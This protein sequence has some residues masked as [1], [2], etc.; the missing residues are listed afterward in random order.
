MNIPSSPSGSILLSFDVLGL[1][2]HVPIR[3]TVEHIE[4]VLHGITVLFSPFYDF[5]TFLQCCLSP[6]IR[7]FDKTVYKLPTDIDIPLK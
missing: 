7:Q 2:I 4:E 5:L 1:Y 6:K 3:G